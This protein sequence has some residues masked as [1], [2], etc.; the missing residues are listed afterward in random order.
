[1][2]MRG[3][4]TDFPKAEALIKPADSQWK[5]DL[6]TGDAKAIGARFY[7]TNIDFKRRNLIRLDSLVRGVKTN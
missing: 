7:L 2:T 6:I 5:S 3:K 1:M 4:L